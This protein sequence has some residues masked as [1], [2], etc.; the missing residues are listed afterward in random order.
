MYFSFMYI[1]FLYMHHFCDFFFSTVTVL[2]SHI[3]LQTPPNFHSSYKLTR[4]C[5][6]DDSKKALSLDVSIILINLKSFWQ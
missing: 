5:G 2:G 6:G 4:E 3:H 1:I